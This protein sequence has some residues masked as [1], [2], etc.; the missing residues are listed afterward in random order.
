MVHRYFICLQFY[1]ALEQ[2][3]AVANFPKTLFPINSRWK[4]QPKPELVVHI[5]P[6]KLTPVHPQCCT[7]IHQQLF[8]QKSMLLINLLERQQLAGPTP[9]FTGGVGGTP[10]SKSTRVRNIN[11]STQALKVAHQRV[12]LNVDLAKKKVIGVTEIT[13]VPMSNT[14][15]VVRLDCREMKIRRVFI[16]GRGLTNFLHNDML[17][18]NDP[19]RFEHCVQTNTVNLSDLYSPDFG[20]HQHHLLRQKLNYI[21]GGISQDQMSADRVDNTNTEELAIILPENLKL[22]LT[23]LHSLHTPSDAPATGL[24]P[25][26]LRSRNTHSDMYTPIQITVE[27]EL[28]NPKN[29]LNFVC[30]SPDKGL[31]HAY[32]V[33]S[34]Y[35][36]STSSWVPC[37]DNLWE[38]CTWSID[39]SIPRTVKDIV[40]LLESPTADG[41]LK[42]G[43]EKQTDPEKQSE[44]GEHEDESDGDNGHANDDN[45]DAD[46]NDE[47]DED[48]ENYDMFVCTGDF[49]NLKEMPHRSDPRKKVVSWSIF[50]PVCAHHVGWA[51]GP[52]QSKELS[53]FNEASAVAPDQDE[54]LDE[55][56]EIE[57][58]ESTSSV[59]LYFLPGLEDMVMNT[60]IFAHKAL[61]FFLKEFGSFPFGS[62]GIV[63]VSGPAYPFH[64][65][66][67]LSVISDNILYPADVIEPMFSVTEDILE[68]IASQWS[69]INIVPQVFN[70]LW[71]TL[72]IARYM[73]FQFIKSLMGSN[74]FRYQIRSKMDQIVKQDVGKTPLGMQN[75]K[76]PISESD[77]NFVRLK[78]PVI[79]FILDRRMTKTDKSFGLSR[80]L[81]KIF[82]QAMSGDLQ[83]GTLS[84][85]HF[86]YVCEKVNRNRLE[87]FFK[88]W[89]YGVGTPVFNITQK[90]NKKR[91][92]IEVTIRQTQLQQAKTVHPKAETFIEDSIAY[93]NDAPVYPT[94]QT[95]LGPMTIRVHEADGTPYE[96]IVDI[97]DSVVKFDVQYNTKFKR[98]K[99]NKDENSEDNPVFSKLGDI[100][101]SEAEMQKWNLADWPKRDEEFLDPFEWIRVDTD[102]EWIAQ[103]NVKQPDYMFGSQLQQDRD[104]EAQIAAIEYFGNQEKP[105]VVYC[106]MLLRTLMD[107]RYF[108]GVR[109]AAA[110]ALG[111]ISK[112]AN[113]F[114][115]IGYLIRA[116]KELFCFENSLVPVSNSFDDFG[117]F[118]L[119]K[120]IPK[121][122][123]QVKDDD[124]H[125]PQNIKSLLFNLLKYNDNSNNEFQDC[126]YIRDLVS[127]LTEAIIPA[128]NEHRA[129]DFHLEREA[130][131]ATYSKEAKFVAKVVDEFARI[132]KL[133]KWVPSYQSIVSFA[134]IEQKIRLARSNL[135]DISLEDLLY[136]TFNKFSPE[137]RAL[138]FK[139]LFLLG[140]L[141]NA[142]ILRYFLEIYL[143]ED[144]TMY[145]KNQ[146]MDALSTSIAEAAVNGTPSMLDDPEFKSLEKIIESGGAG[147]NQTTNMV[148]I[149]ET[150]QFAEMDTRRDVL[151]RATI[152]G[153]IEL[154]R[155]DY[156]I[157]KGLEKTMWELLHTSL[158]S[159]L[160]RRKVFSLCEIMYN[161]V[162]SFPVVISVPCVP[163]EELKKK[164]VAKNLGDGKVVIKREGRFRIQLSAKILLHDQ[165]NKASKKEPARPPLTRVPKASRSQ[166]EPIEEISEEPPK[167]KLKL[168]L[169]S[170]AKTSENKETKR[171]EKQKT[172]DHVAEQ[173]ASILKDSPVKREGP[174]NM[175]VTFIFKKRKLNHLP[176]TNLSAKKLVT[177]NNSQVTIKFPNREKLQNLSSA[178]PSNGARFI[179][180]STRTGTVS[181]SATP[182]PETPREQSP[183]IVNATSPERAKSRRGNDVSEDNENRALG[184][185]QK[186]RG[187]SEK[188]K[189]S[190]N[191]RLE[192]PIPKM[193]AKVKKESPEA[194]GALPR[195]SSKSVSRA[196]TDDSRPV[197]RAA[198]PFS[199]EPSPV[200]KKKKTKIYIH[201][202]TSDTP[203]PPPSGDAG[204]VKKEDSATQNRPKLKLKLSLN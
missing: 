55:F 139:G 11:L 198:S 54:A 179:R 124:G 56:E 137:I 202:R 126:F 46:N 10:K 76:F 35:N 162:D 102:H 85:Q 13:I 53:D 123:G 43:K 141:K 91:S 17:Y 127:A 47:D 92:M 146:L 186:R 38:R 110:K 122:L 152:K 67:G 40:D 154:L 83:N 106:T 164:I 158:I 125:T 184:I 103:F 109:I 150:T 84:T 153:T 12:S 176:P 57:K 147:S 181:L 136:L 48:A 61:D 175:T 174:D 16:N 60:C 142:H 24:T 148:V 116:F 81:P 44:G 183:K 37:I 128:N 182:F 200:T 52:F 173:L 15:R 177:I 171:Q 166:I 118:F 6:H 185:N 80:V 68:C 120:S 51:V 96:H 64:N 178:P 77:L 100:L 72:G 1:F 19:L 36:I 69:T 31:W 203:S 98:L 172:N 93:L 140:G 94:Q 191:A 187:D 194:E 3:S 115:G 159:L 169:S 79:L 156:S 149:E 22:E 75:F 163:F 132:Q 90:F 111:G 41:K 133:D 129:V 25:L 78:A 108:Y 86:Q 204:S 5:Y 145:F 70:D 114:A 135:I 42:T 192:K 21:F 190:H 196:S 66:A 58:D 89:V 197:S 32:T 7:H 20:I 23:D 151:A 88:Q 138:A 62:Y 201:D 157:G 29:G 193:E 121:F 74:E 195:L 131:N 143:L 180:I 9:K 50:S 99:K 26:P 39:I 119:Q 189:S 199:S 27:Y 2:S 45:D 33:N 170:N 167:L 117:K 65:Y 101:Q 155:R 130:A 30:H 49:N 95:F 8:L 104:I 28:S 4:S 188:D 59:M 144:S 107:S 82:L 168:T 160:D 113:N 63:F 112:S 71:C 73:C 105:T 34:E 134:C 165:K 14:L 18:I 161:E 87:S 97:K